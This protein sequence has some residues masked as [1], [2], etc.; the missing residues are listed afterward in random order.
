FKRAG[1]YALVDIIKYL[2]SKKEP[3]ITEDT[4]K[5]II[6]ESSKI[7]RKKLLKF[8]NNYFVLHKFGVDAIKRNI[9]IN[10]KFREIADSYKRM[11]NN[12]QIEKIR[13]LK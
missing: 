10:K 2:I 4:L 7:P 6:K 13:S 9:E 1:I 5:E 3:I 8:L 12:P 11:N